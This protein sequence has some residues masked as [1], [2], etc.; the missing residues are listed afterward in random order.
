[1]R[2][3]EAARTNAQAFGELFDAYYPRILRYILKRVQDAA[4]AQDITANTFFAAL[5]NLHRFSWRQGAGFSSWLYAI[6]TNEIRQHFRKAQQRREYSLESMLEAGVEFA[7]PTDLQEELRE[8]EARLEQNKSIKMLRD[9]LRTLPLKYQETL[10]LRY[11]EECSIEEIAEILHKRCG[12][13]KSLLSRGKDLLERSFERFQTM[14]PSSNRSIVP[15][16]T[17]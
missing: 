10:V 6:A 14:Q 13:V 4:L 7:D 1:M 17:L 16:D 12:T 15:P 2:L 11:L 9:V 5:K 8:A 3:V